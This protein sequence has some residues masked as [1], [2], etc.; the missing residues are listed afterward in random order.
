MQAVVALAWAVAGFIAVLL[1]LA[2]LGA[3]ILWWGW[4]LLARYWLDGRYAAY[5]EP[6]P[7]DGG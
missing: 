5:V 1:A 4:C 3:G 2:A 7:E 6:P